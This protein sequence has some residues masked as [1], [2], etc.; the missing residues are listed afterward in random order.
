MTLRCRGAMRD[1]SAVWCQKPPEP[2]LDRETV[3]GII[4]TLGRLGR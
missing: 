1:T 4:L 3:D 2:A